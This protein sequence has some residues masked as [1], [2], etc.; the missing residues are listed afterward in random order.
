MKERS[1]SNSTAVVPVF[2][3][4]GTFKRH[5]AAIHERKKPFKWKI[6]DACFSLKANL[7]SHIAAIHDLN[8]EK[9]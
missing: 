8:T 9:T 4:I 1:H 6:C 7:K 2:F 5:N 3:N